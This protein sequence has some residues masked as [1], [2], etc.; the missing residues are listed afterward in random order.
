[1]QREGHPYPGAAVWRGLVPWTGSLLP[2]LLGSL[3]HPAHRPS[4]ESRTRRSTTRCSSP[5]GQGGRV[6]HV[7]RL[8]LAGNLIADPDLS[9]AASPADPAPESPGAQ[10]SDCANARA[11][12]GASAGSGPWARPEEVCPILGQSPRIVDGSANDDMN[13]SSS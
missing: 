4:A 3:A 7:R 5:S 8:A 9:G 2:T 11:I 6:C 13:S 10:V 1:M 12:Q